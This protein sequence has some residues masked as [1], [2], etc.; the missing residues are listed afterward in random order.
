MDFK[1]TID[2]EDTSYDN[3]LIIDGNTDSIESVTLELF[4]GETHESNV[5]F[6]QNND[7]LDRLIDTLRFIRESITFSSLNTYD[8]GSS[9]I[10]YPPSP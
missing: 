7:N 1:F 8:S 4:D 6:I 9:D 2:G 5:F 3:S 10:S